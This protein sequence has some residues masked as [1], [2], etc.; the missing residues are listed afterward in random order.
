MAVR[1]LFFVVFAVLGGL[2]LFI[3]GMNVMTDGL[4]A[5]AGAKLQNLLSRATRRRLRGL[6]LGMGLGALVHSSA[7]TVMLVGFINAGLMTLEQSVAP[8]L[9]ANIGTTLSMQAIS[10][11]LGDYCFVAIALGFILNMAAR[12]PT[13]R[14]FGRA[15]LGFGLLFLGMNT[16]SAAIKPHRDL[17]APLLQNFDGSTPLGLC[18]GIGISA[19]LTAIWQSSGATIAI[20][21]ALISAGVFTSLEQ[22]Y[23]IVLGAHIGTCATA[24]LGS[25]GT[26]IEAR[27]SA[28][29][30]LFFNVF[31]TALAAA[32]Q[33]YF[34]RLAALTSDDLT[35]QTANMNTAVMVV[36]GLLVLAVAPLYARLVRL[37]VFSRK[38][39]PE[40]SF[41]D[42][43][44]LEYPERAIAAVIKELHRIARVA[45]ES[46]HLDARVMLLEPD[47]RTV[48]QIRLNENIIDDIK[49]A[50]SEYLSSMTTRYLSRRQTLLIQHLDRCMIDIERIGDHV[51]SICDLSLRRRQQPE[52]MFDRESTEALFRLYEE[53]R[54]VLNMVIESLAPGHRHFQETAQAILDARDRY[55][56]C[57]L[58]TRAA[59]T[60]K[61]EEKQV[62]PIAAMYYMEYVSALD[63]I[64]K[65]A[66]SI[67]LAEQRPDFRIK[68]RKLKRRAEQAPAIEIPEP[69]DPD[70]FLDRLQKE[71]YL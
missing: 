27:R 63:R 25:I 29:S 53:A 8:M 6:A 16:M 13:T 15:L 24:M 4:R 57:S 51:D 11:K 9:G 65:H 2:A 48:K 59:F 41:L 39:R 7:A 32:A 68:R 36:A 5:A 66:K 31:N 45:Q 21:F 34:I 33:P 20:A 54:R 43:A 19:G 10:F 26:N 64:V 70:D 50:C 3:F 60:Q 56:E 22:V 44:L 55:V 67:A 1:E 17:L 69:V 71:D 38:P 28:F 47:R 23:P 58:N 46:L 30:H 42:E 37:I 61:A 40:P 62:A 35:R 12:K 14:Q 52:A 18:I 49:R